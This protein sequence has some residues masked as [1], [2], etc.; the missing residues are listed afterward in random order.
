MAWYSI[1]WYGM[2][3]MMLDMEA[4]SRLMSFIFWASSFSELSNPCR[5]WP[6]ALG[7]CCQI[8]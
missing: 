1:V 4:L 3:Y 6:N 5:P 7:P 8:K 2:Y